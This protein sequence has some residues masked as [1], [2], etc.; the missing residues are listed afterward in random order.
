MSLPIPQ[1]RAYTLTIQTTISTLVGCS[2]MK[3]QKPFDF[4]G[5]AFI[6]NR[7]ILTISFFLLLSNIFFNGR[8]FRYGPV[9]SPNIFIERKTHHAP[10]LDGT[11][12]KDRFRI[13]E[14]RVNN[15][16]DGTYTAA[17]IANEYRAKG[18]DAPT[19]DNVHFIAQGVQTSFREKQLEPMLRVFYNRTAFQLPGD[20]RLRIS[21]DTDLTFIREDHLDGQIRRQPPSNWRRND[22]GIDFPFNYVKS[23]D[24]LRFPY[25][26]LET[27][28]QTHLG[29]EPPAWLTSLVESHLVHEVPRFS[30]YLHGA[31]HFYRERLPLLP[32]WLSE[33]NVDIR[34]P[35]AEN[36]GLTRSRSFKPLIDGRYRRAMIEERERAN[37]QAVVSS[38]QDNNN[39]SITDVEFDSQKA[40][41]AAASAKESWRYSTPSKREYSAVPIP[42]VEQPP[43]PPK[44]IEPTPPKTNSPLQPFLDNKWIARM[45]GGKNNNNEKSANNT[46]LGIPVA[47]DEPAGKRR[48]KVRVEPKVFF[49]NERT[50]ISWLQFCALLLTVALSLLNFGDQTARIIGGVFIAISAVVAIYALYRFEKRAW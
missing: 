49:A 36:I 27:K 33:L 20:Q 41:A 44:S 26:V 48:V 31:C 13:D 37:Q 21:L 45:R 35:R 5:N 42:V 10:W 22:I 46:P 12:V 50:F 2:G 18:V 40:T 16:V 47:E 25:A 32:W 3:A 15:F 1:S 39:P 17:T 6:E 19:V 7:N 11:S 43:T 34:K 8:Y 30:K 24:I 29:Q 9:S 23:A 38:S 4:D 14:N 28:L